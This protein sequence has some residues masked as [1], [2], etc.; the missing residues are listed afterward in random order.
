MTNVYDY[1]ISK[2]G[3]KDVSPN[4]Y[5][6]ISSLQDAVKQLEEKYVGL[7]QDVKRLEEENIETSN[8]LY[9]LSNS[10]DAV[11]ARI[12]ILTAEKFLK[13]DV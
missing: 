5:E 2:Y 13:E 6:M 4:L 9:E 3:R 1:L 12:D 10:L 8:V 11:D 7:L